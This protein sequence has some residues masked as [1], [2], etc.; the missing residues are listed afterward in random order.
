[1]HPRI[2]RDDLLAIQRTCA[3]RA[4]LN[5]NR[6]TKEAAL[7]L[8]VS[9]RTLQMWM[10]RQDLKTLEACVAAAADTSLVPPGTRMMRAYK[11]YERDRLQSALAEHGHNQTYAARALGVSRRAL[12]AKL[13]QYRLRRKDTQ[14]SS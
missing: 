10:R 13:K 6:S 1:M 7:E 9:T 11:L 12:A 3:A 8:G 14:A 5:N 2:F 4:L